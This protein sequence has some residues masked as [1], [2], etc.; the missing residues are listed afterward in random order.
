MHFPEMN[1]NFA[2]YKIA[3]HRH[4]PEIEQE[5]TNIGGKKVLVT[6][7][8]HLIPCNRGILTT[9]YAD[10]TE[11]ITPEE[12]RDIYLDMYKNEPFI[13]ILPAGT[14]PGI[15]SVKGSNYC[16]I[17]PNVDERNNR[18]IVVSVVDN[19]IKGAAGQA[20]QNANLVCGLDE[21]TGLKDPG[22]YL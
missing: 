18:L 1:E 7:T 3:S 4:T 19:L 11:G 14:I 15:S 8:P 12:L 22:Y 13:R 21:T 6:F 10:L 2:A 20:V 16:D 17:L 5:L 9:C